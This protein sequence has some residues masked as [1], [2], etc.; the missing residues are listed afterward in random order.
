MPLT[1]RFT[2]AFKKDFKRAEKQRK[3]LTKLEAI[4]NLL[5]EGS[6]LPERNRD[7][8]LGGNWSSYRECHVEPD[9]L[10]IYRVDGESLILVRLGSHSELF[11]K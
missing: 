2:S 6:P 4:L 10:L 1:P 8:N 5:I 3:D 9:W 7:H 11:R